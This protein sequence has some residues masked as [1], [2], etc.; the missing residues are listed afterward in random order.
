M[1]IKVMRQKLEAAKSENIKAVERLKI[2]EPEMES[3]KAKLK[4]LGVDDPRNVDKVLKSME[5]ELGELM[6]QIEKIET[7]ALL[8]ADNKAD[9]ADLLKELE[10]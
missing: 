2:L 4:E 8:P 9:E 5:S 3:L 1:D 6:K 7:Q 10:L